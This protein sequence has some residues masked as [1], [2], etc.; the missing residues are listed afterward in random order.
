[1]DWEDLRPD[2]KEHSKRINFGG[3]PLHV[4]EEFG[5]LHI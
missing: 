2:S 5:E 1:M 4:I 3:V